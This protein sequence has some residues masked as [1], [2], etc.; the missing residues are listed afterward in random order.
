M[1]DP[2]ANLNNSQLLE[3][4]LQQARQQGLLI[5]ENLTSKDVGHILGGGVVNPLPLIEDGIEVGAPLALED[6]R[7]RQRNLLLAVGALVLLIVL[8][9]NR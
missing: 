2:F 3:L 8:L 9:R 6:L 1:S 4:L 7:I 5:P